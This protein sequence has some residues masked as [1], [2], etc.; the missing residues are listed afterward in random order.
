MP[1]SGNSKVATEA[2]KPSSKDDVDAAGCHYFD[3]NDPGRQ[4][5]LCTWPVWSQLPH[6][7]LV[8]DPCLL[9][10]PVSLRK[11]FN[12]LSSCSRISSDV[13]LHHW[14]SPARRLHPAHSQ[15]PWLRQLRVWNDCR[16]CSLP[17]LAVLVHFNSNKQ[18]EHDWNVLIFGVIN[19]PL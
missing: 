11:F 1:I 12:R 17:T 3:Q 10:P 7:S 4:I 16:L 13:L 6:R 14:I 2:Q 18:S 8:L 9:L 5:L 19:P 15:P